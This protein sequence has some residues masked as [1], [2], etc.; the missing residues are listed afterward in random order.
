MTVAEAAALAAE[1]D[2]DVDDIGICHAC[3]SIVTMAIDAGNRTRSAAPS[4]R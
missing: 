1:L 2:I 3:L 4:S